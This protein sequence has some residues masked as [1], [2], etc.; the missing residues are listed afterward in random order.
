MSD[1][2]ATQSNIKGKKSL[3]CGKFRLKSIVC[4]QLKYF[5]LNNNKK[6]KYEKHNQNVNRYVNFYFFIWFS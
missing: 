4:S 2:Y 3:F 1:F 5:N 6:D